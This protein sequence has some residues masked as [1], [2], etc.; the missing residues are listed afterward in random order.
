MNLN[1]F[2]ASLA[3][4]V[5]LLQKLGSY[6]G[7]YCHN[8]PPQAHWVKLSCHRDVPPALT[9]SFLFLAPSLGIMWVGGIAT[10]AF[11]YLLENLVDVFL[12]FCSISGKCHWEGSLGEPQLTMDRAGGHIPSETLPAGRGCQIP[13]TPSTASLGVHFLPNFGAVGSPVTAK[14]SL[15]WVLGQC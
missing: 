11:L 10:P 1:H 13:M 9:P 12:S 4:G 5:T 15:L 7:G 8:P 3:S 2:C 14:T 6:L